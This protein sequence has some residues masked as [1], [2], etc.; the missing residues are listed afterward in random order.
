MAEKKASKSTLLEEMKA[1]KAETP[2]DFLGKYNIDRCNYDIFPVW[3]KRALCV[4]VCIVCDFK[5]DW[6]TPTSSNFTTF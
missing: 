5:R 4:V 6:K 2:L 1:D 3:V